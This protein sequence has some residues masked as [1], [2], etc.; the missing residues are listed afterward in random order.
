[1]SEY[2]PKAS[3]YCGQCQQWLSVENVQFEDIFLSLRMISGRNTM[4]FVC[5]HCKTI[6]KSLVVL[7]N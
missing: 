6:Q 3:T 4:T 1:M 5:P 2:V 7:G